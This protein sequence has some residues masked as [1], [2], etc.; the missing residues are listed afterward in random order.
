MKYQGPWYLV[1][2]SNISDT[3]DHHSF[4]AK[5]SKKMDK[6]Y[7]CMAKTKAYGVARVGLVKF[8][9]EIRI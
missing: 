3:S 7:K 1:P 9:A 2:S 4:S 8:S 6:D 5:I